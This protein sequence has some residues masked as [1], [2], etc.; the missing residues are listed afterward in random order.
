MTQ[1]GMKAPASNRKSILVVEDNE[2]NREILTGILEEDN[3]TVLTAA[4]GL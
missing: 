2:L 4:D 3:Y 1:H